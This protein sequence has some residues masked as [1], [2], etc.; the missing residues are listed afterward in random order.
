MALILAAALLTFPGATT[1]TPDPMT[2]S[3]LVFQAQEGCAWEGGADP[4]RMN[5]HYIAA[6]RPGEGR[7]E[8]LAAARAYR[9]AVRAGTLEQHVGMRYDG[10]RAWV[11]TAPPA[12]AALALG[13]GDRLRVRVTARWQEGGSALCLAFDYSDPASAAWK[14][15][16]GVLAA[17][18]IPRDG[19]WHTLEA[20]LAV[21]ADAH[22]LVR[23]IIGMD[24]TH[25]PAPGRVTL[26]AIA[27]EPADPKRAG[28]SAR[29][30]S[31]LPPAGVSRALY[32]RPDQQWAA[33]TFTGHFTF[34]YDRSFYDPDRGY[35]VEAL[36]ED[37]RAA[38]GGYD[39]VILWH[40]YPRIGVDDRN[41]FDFFRDMPGGLEGLRGVVDRFH[42][43]GVRVFLPYKPWDTGTRREGVPDAEALGAM[44]AALD[45]DGIYLD[46]MGEVPA[47]LRRVVDAVKPG[48]IIASELHPPVGQLSVMNQSWA[49]WL[50]DP[51]PPGMLHLKWI[52]PR[53]MQQQ[54]RRW[55]TRHA[56]EIEAALFNGSGMVVWE[57]VFG[58]HN[59]WAPEDRALWRR[60]VAIL[61]AF[62]PEFT[63]DAWD[64]FY[65]A[66]RPDLFLHRW[67]GHPTTLF[68]F[69][70]SGAPRQEAALLECPVPEGAAPDTLRVV[71]LWNRRA[72]RYEITDTGALRIFGPAERL[73][74]LAMVSG[75]DPRV[76]AL[77]ADPGDSD[78]DPRIL[79]RAAQS[80]AEP[81]P[82]ARAYAPEG[83]VPPGMVPVAGGPVRMNLRHQ[84]R[85]CGCYPDPGTP[86]ERG[87][88]FLWGSPHD[89][90]LAHEYTVEVAPFLM[91]E[92]QV[93]N[94]EFKRFL[95]ATGYAPKHALNF[96]KHW[97]DG[98]MP[99]ETADLPVV[100]VDLDDA[101]AYARWAGKRLPTEP[102]WQGA[103][104]GSDGREW[105]W[106]NAFDPAK[107]NPGG[108]PMP[109]RSLPEGR[110]PAGCYH[111]SGNVWE[112]TESERDDGHTRFCI[113]RGG[114]WFKPEGSGWYVQGG[115]QP[116]TRHTKFLLQWPGLDR[117]ATV[118]FRCAADLP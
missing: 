98:V 5:A 117:C 45:A 88:D 101:R 111:M 50:D 31:A 34:M 109:V 26:R 48:A 25:D 47:A 118:G 27:L 68:T 57:N 62:A 67:P 29:F 72:L 19:A 33:G 30:L 75:D 61:R 39:T 32:D 100:Y 42:R 12:A 78:D 38:F 110:S 91:D 105:P 92:A 15:W 85:E 83:A 64:P 108:A 99:P 102:E 104:Q 54:I 74:C 71:D 6:P 4:L 52:E 84:R 13:P 73:G 60:A 87:R 59:P 93:S 24:A 77:L 80:V 81:K 37:G 65:P 82:V 49:Q 114:G 1:E 112:W 9:D 8:W 11:R 43:A 115:P 103:A 76:D 17:L 79:S 21:P 28:D 107:C 97:P 55:D 53:H 63:S 20:D 36:L 16:S 66:L 41:Q 3:P 40:A 56:E 90:E 96:L 22:G 69:R 95:D 23:P 106:G 86:P 44:L 14:G 89:G 18:D 70:Y 10:V 113:L 58:A 35:Q 51:E 116:C 94:A 46:T 7:A 2:L